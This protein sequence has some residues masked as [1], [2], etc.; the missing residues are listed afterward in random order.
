MLT[1]NLAHIGHEEGIFFS[2]LARV[3]I[4]LF[5]TIRQNLLDLSFSIVNTIFGM[6]AFNQ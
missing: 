1:I 6:K 4:N 2:G 3:D 5:D